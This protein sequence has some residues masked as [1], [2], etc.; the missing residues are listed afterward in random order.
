MFLYAD[1]EIGAA[2]H[3][4][5]IGDNH[6]RSPT[7]AA[8]SR[9]DPCASDLPVVHPMRRESSYLEKG[10]E[11]I[12]QRVDTGARRH[13]A[14]RRVARLRFGAAA[15]ADSFIAPPQF[16]DEPHHRRMVLGIFWRGEIDRRFDN[17]HGFFSWSQ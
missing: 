13:F 1:G 5:I 8:N 14:A 17:G 12:D 2:L 4:R 10:R 16:S 9:D 3:G 6:A 11:R 7:D 15:V